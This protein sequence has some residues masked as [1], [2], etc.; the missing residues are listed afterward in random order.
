[1]IKLNNNELVLINGGFSF[2]GTIIN[3]FV[4][5]GKFI[6]ELG[7]GLGSSIRR[8]NSKNLCTVR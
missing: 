1:M 7:R 4:S 6:Y 3:A 2:T 8:I 5:A